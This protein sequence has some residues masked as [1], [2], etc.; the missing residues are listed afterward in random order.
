MEAQADSLLS[1]V[2]AAAAA[3]RH[4]SDWRRDLLRPG[5]RSQLPCQSLAHKTSKVISKLFH[6]EL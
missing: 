4:G 6:L 3:E 2:T 5:R 1:P